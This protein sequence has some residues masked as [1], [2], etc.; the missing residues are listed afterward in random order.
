MHRT[1]RRPL[2]LLGAGDREYDAYSLLQIAATH[3]VVLVDRAAPAWIRPYLAGEVAV[4]LGDTAHVIQAVTAFTIEHDVGGVLTYS[5]RHAE[6]AARL[7]QQLAHLDLP[8]NA[9][10]AVAACHDEVGFRRMLDEHAFPSAQ[11]FTADA[12]DSAIEAARL[13][14]YPVALRAPG[15]DTPGP[16]LRAHGDHEVRAAF[17]RICRDDALVLG[18]FATTG[19]VVE[20]VGLDGPAVGVEAV[21]TAPTDV[22]TVAIT[23]TSVSPQLSGQVVG[24]SVD[25]HD[26]LLHDAAIGQCVTQAVTACGITT[27]VVHAELRLSSRG[28]RLAALSACLADNLVPLLVARALGINLP[29]VAAAL[30]TGTT[31]ALAA[32]RKGAAAIRF[33][34]PNA[35][36][37]IK[38]LRPLTDFAT[39]PWLDRFVWTRQP[40]NAVLAPPTSGL[41]D[42]LA[43]CVVTGA[44][45]AEC[46]SW[47]DLVAS[48]ATARIEYSLSSPLG[49][50]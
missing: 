19:A 48:H 1:T 10:A 13:L 34:Y 9:P 47:L 7:T 35:T 6:L 5:V 15:A 31:P 8:G 50:R 21:V 25:A 11:S 45:P 39:Q 42:R 30:A 33:L 23:R 43:H 2:L 41:E 24:Y 32:V 20:E 29:Q 18:P 22:R 4:E 36:G 16:G 12:E 44:D 27:G 17:R 40:G 14:G 3:P 28:P 37:R 49:V 26:E 46:A 38:Q